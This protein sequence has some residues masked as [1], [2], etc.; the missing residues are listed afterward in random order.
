M[1][2]FSQPVVSVNN[3]QIFARTSSRR[4]QFLAYQMNYESQHENGMILPVPIRRPA[5]GESLRFIDLRE[6]EDFFDD[7]DDGFPYVQPSFNIS[8]SK[9][10]DVKSAGA[11]KVFEVG[12]YIASFV[13]TMLEFSR[14]DERFT[15]PDSTWSLIPQYATYGFVV[16]QLAAGSLTPHPMAFEFENAN[17]SIYFPTMHIHDGQVHETEEFDHVLYLQHAGFDS[18]VYGYRNSDIADKATGLIRSK[19]VARH[20]CDMDRCNGVVDPD[21]LVHREII[22]GINPNRD[23]SI[24]TFGDPAHPT[25][26]LRPWL[27]Y[28]P[29][30]VFLAA[31]TWFFARR[32]RIKNMKAASNASDR[33]GAK[34]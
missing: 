19:Y 23:T 12:N 7:L 20:F 9:P 8:C 14:L 18:R 25:L 24:E 16:F 21:L 17:D 33:D 13:P 2:I 3:T 11:L 10:V 15:L 6:Y 1:C 30:L 31:A 34:P 5:T 22:R 28:S 4:T 29:W 26:N 27:S 32:A